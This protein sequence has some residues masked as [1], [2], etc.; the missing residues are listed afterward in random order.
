MS[1]IAPH[2]SAKRTLRE[3]IAAL[4]WQYW[5]ARLVPMLYITILTLGL[6]KI[7]TQSFVVSELG[8]TPEQKIRRHLRAISIKVLAHGERVGSGVLL[9]RHDRVYTV[10]TNAHVVQASS[11][12][13][14]LQTHDGQI[15]AAALIAPPTGHNRDLSILR[16]QSHQR[17]Y[18]TAKLA[19]VAPKVGD[20]VWSAGF[21]I[22]TDDKVDRQFND[23]DKAPWGLDTV[24][25]QT[26]HVLPIAIT[27]GYG[28]GFD[29]GIRKGMSG[30]PL[31]DRSGELIGING[32][33]AN[34]LWDTP[35]IL[36]NGAIA[37]DD[38]KAQIHNSSWA[39]PI[40]YVRG[41]LRL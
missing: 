14:Q 28:I 11:A 10:I 22:G 32:V 27:G 1:K 35:E 21:P 33:H 5:V 40:E 13:Y 9:E 41:Y 16:F 15:Y 24:D 3:R 6:P 36:E 34:P 23:L 8:A 38:L 17:N 39:I 19:K 30:G 31:V 4:E 2:D 20:R 7:L 25:G 26:T 29:A 18:I 12:P 37:S